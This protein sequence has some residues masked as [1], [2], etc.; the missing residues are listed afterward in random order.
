MN[1]LENIIVLKDANMDKS[2]KP[3]VV[4]IFGDLALAIGPQF[5]K[6]LETVLTTLL[7]ASTA[8]VDRVKKVF[9]L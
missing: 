8:D 3:Q 4:A 9:L 2:V 5:F 6:Y 1:C 7:Q